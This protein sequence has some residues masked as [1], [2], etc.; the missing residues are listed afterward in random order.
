MDKGILIKYFESQGVLRKSHFE[1]QSKTDKK[2]SSEMKD[3]TLPQS[4][5]TDNVILTEN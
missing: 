1:N 2:K 4:E 5:C 3:M